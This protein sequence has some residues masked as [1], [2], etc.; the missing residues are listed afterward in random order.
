M[1][2]SRPKNLASDA[3]CDKIARGGICFTATMTRRLGINKRMPL[4]FSVE[5]AIYLGK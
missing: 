3:T 2:G 4:K 1:M 5:C